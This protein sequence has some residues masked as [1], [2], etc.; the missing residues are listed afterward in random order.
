MEAITYLRYPQE[1]TKV[2]A[3]PAKMAG[4]EKLKNLKNK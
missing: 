3:K 4:M 2:N 1:I